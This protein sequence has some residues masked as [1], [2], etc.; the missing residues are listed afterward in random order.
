MVLVYI[1]YSKGVLKILIAF[2]VDFKLMRL[3]LVYWNV[4]LSD[5]TY[6]FVAE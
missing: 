4:F 3:H 6:R 1:V 2:R 5:K